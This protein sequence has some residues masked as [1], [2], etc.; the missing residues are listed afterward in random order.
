M[1]MGRC[2]NF[3]PF[4]KFNRFPSCSW[5]KSRQIILPRWQV[6]DAL[7]HQK[8]QCRLLCNREEKHLKPWRQNLFIRQRR[9]QNLYVLLSRKFW[10]QHLFW[11]HIWNKYWNSNVF[12]AS[13]RVLSQKKFSFSLV[14]YNCGSFGT[15]VVPHEGDTSCCSVDEVPSQPPVMFCGHLT[16]RVHCKK[17]NERDDYDALWEYDGYKLKCPQGT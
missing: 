4:L 8:L 15:A 14:W 6:T 9:C 2:R 11:M 10:Y 5:P 1:R 16:L 7:L 13:K 3:K 12:T 17:F